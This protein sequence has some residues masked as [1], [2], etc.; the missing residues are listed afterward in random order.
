MKSIEDRTPLERKRIRGQKERITGLLVRLAKLARKG[1]DPGKSLR[2]FK[3]EDEY[4]RE[5][6]TLESQ[7]GRNEVEEFSPL[8]DQVLE[9][10]RKGSTPPLTNTETKN[11]YRIAEETK[12]GQLAERGDMR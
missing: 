1:V 6:I 2:W 7:W 5:V 3:I 10:A 12:T 4:H 9:A 11:P 8:Y